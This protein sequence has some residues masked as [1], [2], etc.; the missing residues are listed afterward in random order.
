V[1]PSEEASPQVAAIVLTRDESKT[2]TAARDALAA[3][4]YPRLRVVLSQTA[5]ALGSAGFGRAA[6]AAVATLHEPFDYFLFCRDD[7]VLEPEAVARMVAAAQEHSAGVVGPKLVAWSEPGRLLRVGLAVNKLGVAVSPVDPGDLDQGQHDDTD[8]VFALPG[9]CLLV[10][11]SL[12]RAVGGFDEAIEVIGDD[13]SLCWRARVAGAEVVV[14]TSTSAV[15]RGDDGSSSSL[16]LSSSSALLPAPA[17]EQLRSRNQLRTVLTCYGRWHLLRV[18]PQLMVLQVVETVVAIVTL[19]P[20]RA[21]AAPRAWAWNVRRVRSLVRVRRQL[22]RSREVRDREVRRL[23]LRGVVRPRLAARRGPGAAV[24]RPL[25]ARSE[26]LRGRWTGGTVLVALGLAGVLLLGSRHLVTRGVPAVG[27]LVGLGLPSGLGG[28]HTLLTMGLIPVGV[29][30]AARALRP[31][32]SLRAPIAAAVAYAALPIP[33]AA[34]AAGQW[35]PLALYAVAPWWLATLPWLTASPSPSP[36]LPA[37]P[38]PKAPTLPAPRC[39]RRQAAVDAADAPAAMAPVASGAVST[40]PRAARPPAVVGAPTSGPRRSAE[41]ELPG[42]PV[43]PSTTASAGPAAVGSS[44]AGPRR[45]AEMELPGAPAVPST[46]TP[47]PA[48]V[49][50]STAGPRRSAE[51][52]LPGPPVVP[53]ASASAGPAAVGSST[54]VSRR[55]AEME[56]PGP[57]AVPSTSASAGPAAVGSST[58]VSR[59][60]AEMVGWLAEAPG[61]SVPRAVGD[62][63]V[64]AAG[65]DAPAGGQ[66]SLIEA[67]A[68]E[69]VGSLAEAWG[70]AARQPLPAMTA[71]SAEEKVIRVPTGAVIPVPAGQVIGFDATAVIREAP[72]I[73]PRRTGDSIADAVAAADAIVAALHARGNRP[74]VLPAP[75]AVVETPVEPVVERVEVDPAPA[76][77]PTTRRPSILRRGIVAGM[78]AGLAGAVVPSAP[79]LLL[80][81]TVVLAVGGLLAFRLR[82]TFRLLLTGAGAALLAAVLQLPWAGDPRTAESWGAGRGPRSAVEPVDLLGF[83]GQPWL[84]A[85][86]VAALVPLLV[87]RRDRLSGAIRAWTLALAAWGAALAVDRAGVDL[88]FPDV[89]LLLCLAGL[90][91][92]LAVGLGIAAVERDLAPP[93]RRRVRRRD[94]RRWRAPTHPRRLGFRPLTAGLAAGA[95]AVAAVPL[96]ADSLDGYWGMPRG[97]FGT[98][99]GF[100][101]DDV[102]AHDGRVLW[103][104]PSDVLPLPTALVGR[105]AAG[106]TAGRPWLADRW[107]SRPGREGREVHSSLI[108]AAPDGR[109]LG[110]ALARE[111]VAYVVLPQRL[112]PA[113]AAGGRPTSHASPR[114]VGLLD[115]QLDLQR[116]EVDPAVVVYRNLAFQEAAARHAAGPPH[117]R[118]TPDKSTWPRYAGAAAWAVAL[119]VLLVS[120]RRRSGARL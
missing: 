74:L 1:E 88:P 45:S 5:A 110:R 24:L 44:T 34:L 20:G 36:S 91:V 115:G 109:R 101:Y 98:A 76:P 79:V 50:S 106:I 43:V 48:A 86:L 35:S 58:S 14:A 59:R 85:L 96:L 57:R 39:T 51:M 105:P 23:Q 68:A 21:L 108:G 82:G 87:G 7:V 37:A 107:R 63:A 25:A 3:Q 90:G 81:V 100:V 26:A 83:R 103:L 113:S 13:V 16:S 2:L 22:A 120:L 97:D 119:L 52:E 28:V 27:E 15:A 41:M 65:A 61:L 12:Y 32:G 33:Y 66:R 46:P 53:S 6:N 72:A 94:R 30:G 29:I 18:L 11:A 8:S 17:A 54:S 78:T 19:R 69:V 71:A 118:W 73:A 42:P 49:G 104:G 40:T 95:I 111:R 89:E 75:A 10:E 60:P 67:A 99:L 47:T 77:V 114:M 117:R 92:A 64:D 84:W 102:S 70:E 56:L 80:A 9:A 62:R 31:L 55:P 4:T 38:S 93:Q 116:V 112:A